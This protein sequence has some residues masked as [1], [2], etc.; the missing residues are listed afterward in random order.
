MFIIL[1]LYS[2]EK[3]YKNQGRVWNKSPS[4]KFS[5]DF[6][7]S[8]LQSIHFLNSS[9]LISLYWHTSAHGNRINLSHR[10]QFSKSDAIYWY[11]KKKRDVCETLIAPLHWT[12]INVHHRV[13]KPLL[14]CISS[15]HENKI[16]FLNVRSIGVIYRYYL[17][18]INLSST[19][20]MCPS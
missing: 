20:M 7:K 16:D 12:Y 6:T 2:Y 14:Q 17:R 13:H 18:C 15:V 4:W 10:H 11:F 1:T 9:L 8:I 5:K 19:S 3:Q